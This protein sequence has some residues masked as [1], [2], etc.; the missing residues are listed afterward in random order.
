MSKDLLKD[1]L[2]NKD[3]IAA[4]ATPIG[5]GGVGVVKVSGEKAIE[6]VEAVFRAKCGLK[7]SEF[8]SHQM[9]Y[10][11]IIGARGEPLDDALVVAMR[12]PRSYTREDV[13]EI[14]LHGGPIILQKVLDMIIENGARHALAGEFTKRAFL[15]G[16]IDLT[17]AEAVAELIDAKSKKDLEIQ[18]KKI[19]GEFKSQIKK[20]IKK[21]KDVLVEIEAEIEFSDQVEFDLDENLLTSKIKKTILATIQKLIANYAASKVFNEGIR[22]AIMGPPNVGKST[23]LNQLLGRK[24][25]IVTEVPGTTRDL[26]EDYLVIEQIPFFLTDTAGLQES[27]DKVELIGI[28]LARKA[29]KDADL[30]LLVVDLNNPD[31]R[32]LKEL[33]EEKLTKTIIVLNKVD[34]TKSRAEDLMFIKD[35]VRAV[36]IIS[37][38]YGTG[39]EK[40]K[41]EMVDFAYR[42]LDKIEHNTLAPNLRQKYHLEKAAELIG[43]SIK[44]LKEKKGNELAAID[45]AEALGELEKIIGKNL[46]TDV[47][48]E[49]FN[50]FCIGK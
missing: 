48:G 50:K 43:H 38:K 26:I 3:T 7:V 11:Q 32:A 16:R 33:K 20:T 17:Q 35:Q 37:A 29:V 44:V 31:W 18:G 12:A 14:Q 8:V 25:A 9:Y 45:L 41:T 13:V 42:S 27:K 21:I 39:I 5:S 15:N 22:V 2:E 28:N 30:I 36:V 40:L 46:N 24:K 49:I 19:A 1:I 10:G 6:V 4:V 34:L 23:L 47:L